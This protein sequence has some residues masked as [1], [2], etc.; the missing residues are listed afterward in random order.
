MPA[1]VDI[2]IL[3]QPLLG[4]FVYLSILAGFP[5]LWLSWLLFLAPFLLRRWRWG[6][7]INRTPFDLPIAIFLVALLVGLAVS[8]GRA[9]S[10][11]ALQT[12]L[13]C[14]LAYY[15]GVANGIR[16]SWYWKIVIFLTFISFMAFAILTFAQPHIVGKI[17]PFNQWLFQ[18][19]RLLPFNYDFHISPNGLGA[20]MAICVPGFLAFSLLA[21][22]RTMRVVAGILAAFCT[23]LLIMSVSIGGLFATLAAVFL[24]L[25]LWK[26]WTL[27]LY[28]PVSIGGLWLAVSSYYPHSEIIQGLIPTT[29]ISRF[30][31]WKET[32]LLLKERLITGIGLGTWFE[33]HTALVG[34]P[35][36]H[37]PHSEFLQIYSDCGILGVVAIIGFAVIFIRLVWRIWHSPENNLWSV[38]GIGSA[39]AIVALAVNGIFETTIA[40]VTAV[41]VTNQGALSYHYVAIPVLWVLVGIFSVSCMQV[42]SPS[43]EE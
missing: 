23:V 22:D 8:S 3:L 43:A 21:K 15:A 32:L 11:E 40:G 12:F 37:Y 34:F 30:T 25:L 29:L 2:I 28:L 41:S 10:F 5:P 6:I 17:L 19:G 39:V 24:L 16:K 14:I 13:V 35:S 7:I 1:I 38:L 18:A 42:L 33:Q 9:V 4:G 20:L 27:Y 26:P 36:T 31:I